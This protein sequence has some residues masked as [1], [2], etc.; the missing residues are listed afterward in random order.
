MIRR[1]LACLL[2]TAT[3]V[4]LAACAETPDALVVAGTVEDTVATV[5]APLLSVPA[6]V[7][8]SESSQTAQ[9]GASS[10]ALPGQM[11][12]MAW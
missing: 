4:G 6:V 5:A 2:A 8:D 1:W 7:L 3:L 10:T 11:A 12:S 9:G